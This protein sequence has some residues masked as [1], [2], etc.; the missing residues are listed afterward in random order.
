MRIFVFLVILALHSAAGV[1]HSLK[2]IFTASSQVPNFPE[3]VDVGLL[4]DVPI[5]YYDSNTER[6]VPKQDWMK[7]VTEDYPQYWESGTDVLKGF[8]QSFKASIETIKQRFNQTGGVHIFQHMYGCEWD[9]ETGEVN[10]FYQHGYNGEDFIS[11]DLR[12]ETW[13]APK[14][15]AFDTKMKWDN[16]KAWI[17]QTKNYLSQICPDWLKKYLNYGRSSLMRKGR[18]T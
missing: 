17:A 2:Y 10:G 12:T 5:S 11:F 8:Q 13:I 1:T 18:I 4:D 16:N 14:Q 6:K 15:Q 9:D 7:R 3:F